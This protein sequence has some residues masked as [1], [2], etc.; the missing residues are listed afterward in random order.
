MLKSDGHRVFVPSKE[1]KGETFVC[2]PVC[3]WV[4]HLAVACLYHVLSLSFISEACNYKYHYSKEKFVLL[5]LK[6]FQKQKAIFEI[7]LSTF[8]TT[9]CTF[10]DSGKILL[11]QI[12]LQVK[13][14]TR[15][16]VCVCIKSVTSLLWT[17]LGCG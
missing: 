17:A 7:S 15:V 4:G 10:Q 2:L 1:T 9:L 16:C 11:Q 5:V 13:K 8:K 6:L 3:H 14:R 12:F